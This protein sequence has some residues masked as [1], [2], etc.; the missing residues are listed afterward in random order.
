MLTIG[1]V[2]SVVTDENGNVS[3][4]GTNVGETVISTKYNP[5]FKGDTGTGGFMQ[6]T[7]PLYM[8]SKV[9][10]ERIYGATTKE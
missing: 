1:H 7:A 6:F 2:R 9:D 5:G 10:K 8:D 3:D 4:V